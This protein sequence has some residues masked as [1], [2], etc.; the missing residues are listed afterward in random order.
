MAVPTIDPAATIADI[1]K[2]LSNPAEYVRHV[3]AKMHDC[4]RD[5]AEPSV[6]I[7]ATGDAASPHYR[8]EYPSD[9]LP[10]IFGAFHGASHK[11]LVDQAYLVDEHWSRRSMS[12]TAIQA[13]LSRLD[14]AEGTPQRR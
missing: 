5:R 9:P 3:L 8:I 7:L 12:L 2:H 11:K 10:A 13:L 1:E 14:T 4:R 6:R